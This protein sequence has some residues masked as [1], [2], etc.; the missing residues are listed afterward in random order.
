M[1]TIS[2]PTTNT[3]SAVLGAIGGALAML[4]LVAIIALVAMNLGTPA[5]PAHDLVQNTTPIYVDTTPL[6]GPSMY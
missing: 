5:A 1:T 6:S 3:G 2:Y 4:V